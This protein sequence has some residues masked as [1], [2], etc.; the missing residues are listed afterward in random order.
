MRAA[1]QDTTN[2]IHI[3]KIWI[4]ICQPMAISS[5]EFYLRSVGLLLYRSLIKRDR[6]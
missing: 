4:M 6:S 3:L 5:R 2:A 1:D